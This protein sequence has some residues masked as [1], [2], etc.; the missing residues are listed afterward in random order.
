MMFLG[1]FLRLSP[2]TLRLRNGQTIIARPPNGPSRRLTATHDS[3][4]YIHFD[5]SISLP[6]LP[7]L[8]PIKPQWVAAFLNASIASDLSNVPGIRLIENTD[9]LKKST[10]SR[11]DEYL[12]HGHGIDR[13]AHHIGGSLYSV[14]GRALS[15][16]QNDGRVLSISAVGRPK[17]LNRW[18]TGLIQSGSQDAGFSPSDGKFESNRILNYEGL[19]GSGVVISVLD[20][21]ADPASPYFQDTSV[22]PQSMRRL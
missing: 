9:S 22:P 2:D 10:R 11:H 6:E 3:W 4:Y 17:L 1:L 18:T 16:L 5:S 19:D 13:W 21:G 12:V 20:S 8:M 15:S 14:S 7:S